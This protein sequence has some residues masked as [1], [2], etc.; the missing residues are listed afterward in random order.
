[1]QTFSEL[2]LSETLQRNLAAASHDVPTEIQQLSLPAALTG[3]DLIACA[4]TGGGKTAVYA[5]TILNIL[6][7]SEGAGHSHPRALI[8]V[9]TRELAVQ[10]ENNFALYG[11]GTGLR[12]VAI[13]GGAGMGQQIMRLRRGVDVIIATPGRLFDHMEQGNVDLSKVSILVLDEADRLLDMGFM[14]QVKRIVSTI[15]DEGRQTM[16][17]S[18]TMDGD[19]EKLARAYL[20]DPE[21]VNAQPRSTAVSLIEQIVHR[22]TQHEKGDLLMTLLGE[23]KEVEG[24]ALVFTRTRHGA[25]R[26]DQILAEAGMR[27][28][29]IHG[30]ISQNQRERVL[31]RFRAKRIDV[32]VAT[33]VAARG[34]DVPHITHVINYDVPV[35]AEDY[36]HRIGR[37]GRAGRSGKA[38]TFVTH[39]DTAQ[40][41]AIEKL[42]GQR[43]DP[44]PPSADEGRRSSGGRGRFGGGGGGGNFRGGG[45]GGNRSGGGGYGGGSGGGFDRGASRRPR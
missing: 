25:D 39:G 10:V 4:Q 24:G 17:F 13:Y 29:C 19:V 12:G 15:P 42:V 32:L 2:P 38:F 8:L 34:I 35:C 22:V 26:L 41:R 1:M 14:P 33:D 18:A 5:L 30:D 9:P 6:S 28:G 36:I 27:S 37:T 3:G 23:A 21:I 45:Y 40:L 16:L 20:T 43:L 31:A 7:Q 11:K 44:N